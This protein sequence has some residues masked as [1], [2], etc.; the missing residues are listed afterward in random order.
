MSTSSGEGD[1]SLVRHEE[2]LELGKRAYR[3]GTLR[4]RRSVEEHGVEEVV[5][6][7][8]EE[9]D[10]EH[11]PVGPEDSGQIETLPDGSISIPLR[12]EQLLVSKRVV[13]RERIVIR[14]RMKTVHET[15]RDELR[16]E[17][18]EVETEGE[19]GIEAVEH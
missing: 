11:T 10:V 7:L 8:V 17:R 3:S 14:K 15:I 2:Q 16:S 9:A 12:E 4:A 13:V 5:P 18:M 6:R 19:T 1:A